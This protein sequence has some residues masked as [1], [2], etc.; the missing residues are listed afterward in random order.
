MHIE[1]C[2]DVKALAGERVNVDGIDLYQIASESRNRPLRRTTDLPVLAP[3]GHQSFPLEYPLYGTETDMGEDA[4]ELQHSGGASAAE[5][6]LDAASRLP[7]CAV[8]ASW[9]WLCRP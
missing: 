1:E 3:S 9:D 7:A 6:S 5:T 4:G 2:V 8:W